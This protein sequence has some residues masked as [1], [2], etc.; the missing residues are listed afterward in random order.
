MDTQK[1]QGKPGAPLGNTNRAIPEEERKRGKAAIMSLPHA[2][3]QAFKAACET[4][5]GRTLTDAEYIEEWREVA[6]EAV[7]RYIEYHSL[8]RWQYDSPHAAMDASMY[9]G[10]R[11]SADGIVLTIEAT[12]APRGGQVAKL[13]PYTLRFRKCG[14]RRDF[15]KY[16]ID[17]LADLA[18]A[19]GTRITGISME[20]LISG[21]W[22]VVR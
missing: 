20:A 4:A 11:T 8:E 2:D 17:D 6:R 18:Q 3:W 21:K 7:Q 10:I 19:S 15:A 22:E 13:A 16:V 9:G 5:Y 14:E 1:S 12:T